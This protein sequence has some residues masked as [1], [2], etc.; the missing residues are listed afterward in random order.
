M[1]KKNKRK[2]KYKIKYKSFKM[3]FKKLTVKMQLQLKK[4]NQFYKI[5]KIIS[6]KVIKT[7]KKIPY[8]NTKNLIKMEELEEAKLKRFPKK[9]IRLSNC[10]KSSS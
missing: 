2:I 5:N 6:L 3:S 8:Q 1:A 4:L 7:I 9:F 10:K